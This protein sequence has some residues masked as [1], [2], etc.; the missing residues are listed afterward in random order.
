MSEEKEQG[1]FFK[2]LNS[3][4][5]WVVIILVLA[6]SAG[7]IFLNRHPEYIYTQQHLQ[8][9]TQKPVETQ[10]IEK[11]TTTSATILQDTITTY[12]YKKEIKFDKPQRLNIKV[13]TDGLIEIGIANE[14]AK[15]G[16]LYY[17]SVGNLD[18]NFDVNIG[19]EE[20]GYEFFINN[21]NATTTSFTITQIL[22]WS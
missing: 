14:T 18:T 1:G 11:Y 22:I 4:Y 9:Q 15:R 2:F 10:P 6:V 13:S 12:P 5:V 21:I 3:K 7:A 17:N 20:F 16:V 8:N 19:D